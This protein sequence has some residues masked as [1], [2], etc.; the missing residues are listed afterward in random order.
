MATLKRCPECSNQLAE[1]IYGMP[2]QEDFENPNYIIMGCLMDEDLLRY[3]CRECGL[4]I[5]RS[6]RTENPLKDRALGSIVGLAIGDALGAPYEFRP[7]VSAATPIVMDHNNYATPGEWTDDTAMAI[8]IMQA[9][10]KHANIHT[11][12]AQDTLVRIWK[13]WAMTAP[14]VGLQTRQ[15]LM[16]L[17]DESAEE[18]NLVSEA[19]HR[20]TGR[21]GGNGALMRTAPLAFLKLPDEE[22]A[23]V[24]TQISKLTHFDADAA[25]ACI[26]WV[27]AIRHAIKTGEL[28]FEPGFEFLP[29]E[30]KAKWHGFLQEAAE[31]PPVHFENN[32]WVVAAFKAAASAVMIGHD[33]YTKGIEAAIRAGFDTDTVAAI[34][35][36]LLG[37][38][39]GEKY[40]PEEWKEI[41]H[42]WPDFKTESLSAL[43]IGILDLKEKK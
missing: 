27:F 1:A 3:G 17:R 14:D 35:G 22:I 41:L 15:V 32:G 31:H 13:E 40:L 29:E 37:A 24:V 30:A 2:S 23:Q 9:W 11:N 38:L 8:A 16:S 33:D 6:G 21:S 18:A 28:D 36:S 5:Y 39:T 10:V 4:E 26:I 19:L 25:H 42:G 7:P 12:A 34:A 43:T 20:A